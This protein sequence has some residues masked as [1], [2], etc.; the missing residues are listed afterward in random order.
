VRSSVRSGYV[1][2]TR[3]TRREY[4]FSFQD[5]VALRA[6]KQLLDAGLS[7]RR[8]AQ[9]LGRLVDELPAERTLAGV[10][11]VAD[12]DRVVVEDGDEIWNPESGQR[13][14]DFRPVG[15]G[16]APPLR[17]GPARNQP[18]AFTVDADQAPDLAAEEWYQLG[19]ELESENTREA[20]AAYRKAIELAPAHVDAHLNLGRLL[21]EEGR[22]R[23]AADC[24]RQAL[25]LRP[26]D[27]T[28]CFNLAVALEDLGRPM[29][30]LSAYERVIEADSE[31]ADAYFNIAGIYE[32][33]GKRSEAVRYLKTY[34]VLTGGRS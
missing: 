4:R 11:I 27:A 12:G 17:H 29:E 9:A 5:L 32:R 34:K 14:L 25:E 6:V 24:Y 22:V 26:A 31:Y 20:K 15:A 23:T 28:A 18:P 33:L 7:K 19:I 21:H 10:R 3:G 16:G 1:H 13:V 30:A 8:V 2:P